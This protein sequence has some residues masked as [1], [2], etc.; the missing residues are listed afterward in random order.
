MMVEE[1]SQ[2]AELDSYQGDIYPSF[3][4][5]LGGFVIAHQSALTHEPAKG[6]LHHPAPW[7]HFEAA[8]VV[9]AFDHFHHELAAEG[10]DPLGKLRSTIPA[11]DPQQAQS[12]KPAQHSAQQGFG[13]GAFGGAGGRDL[14]AQHQTQRVHEQVSLAALDA[15]GRIVA[16]RAAVRIEIGRA[17]CRERV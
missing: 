17:S 7:Q 14:D 1:S 8:H 9:G 5:G 15:F 13:P 10:F 16:H 4:A 2:S 3:R 12:G 11:I 6:A